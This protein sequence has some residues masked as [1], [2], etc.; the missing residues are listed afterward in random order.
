MANVL[1]EDITSTLPLNGTGTGDS[2]VKVPYCPILFASTWILGS[3][4]LLKPIICSS[5]TV[6]KRIIL[7]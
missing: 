1:F 4:V 6:E 7:P 5:Y 2:N 3:D